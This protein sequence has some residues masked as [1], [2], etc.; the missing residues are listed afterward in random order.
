ML[1]GNLG[2]FEKDL[3]GVGFTNYERVSLSN[4]DLTTADFKRPTGRAG[5]PAQ[6]RLRPISF[7][8]P[9]VRSQ[10]L[11]TPEEGAGARALLDRAIAAK[12]GLRVARDQGITAATTTSMIEAAFRPT[13]RLPRV[14]QSRADQTTL[15]GVPSVRSST[16][17][18]GFVI[19][20]RARGAPAAFATCAAR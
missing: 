16:S 11:I 12:G 13:R 3:K 20:E 4:L 7:Q 19:R 9:S 17:S 1:V 5:A 18:A 10:P 8:E 2:A 14:S 6:P 15:Q